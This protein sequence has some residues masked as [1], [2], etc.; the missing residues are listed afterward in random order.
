MIDHSETTHSL[1][2][3]TTGGV[4]PILRAE[5]AAAL[6]GAMAA[7][8]YIGGS[9]IGF[10]VLFIA[11]D[12]AMLAY[13]VNGRPG[14]RIYNGVHTY[15]CSAALACAGWAGGLPWLC[16]GGL[17]W[18][19]HIG[20]DRALGFGLKRS[21]GFRDTDL[22]SAGRPAVLMQSTPDRQ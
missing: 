9:W 10:A 1:T 3:D 4:I 13:L 8:G 14:A 21:D 20:F 5:G 19:A 15:L 22:G 6:A 18:I 2:S 16:A 17:I 11:P 7:Y 12:L